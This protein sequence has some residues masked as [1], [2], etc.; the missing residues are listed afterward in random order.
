MAEECKC[1]AQVLDA[2][3]LLFSFCFNTSQ[4]SAVGIE[5]K[6]D[7]SGFHSWQGENFSVISKMSRPAKGGIQPCQNNPHPLNWGLF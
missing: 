2:L 1:C 3:F 7:E 6:M 4:N 5:C